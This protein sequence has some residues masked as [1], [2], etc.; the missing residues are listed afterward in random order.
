MPL[1]L[2]RDY[3]P[4][5][6]G[7]TWTRTRHGES[8]GDSP[9]DIFAEYDALGR[10]LYSRVDDVNGVREVTNTWDG[11]CL[12][13]QDIRGDFGRSESLSTCD[14]HGHPLEKNTTCFTEGD[15]GAE[16]VAIEDAP[17]FNTYEGDAWV[18]WD[19]PEDSWVTTFRFEGTNLVELENQVVWAETFF[20]YDYTW[21]GDRLLSVTTHSEDRGHGF[22]WGPDTTTWTYDKAGRITERDEAGRV[23]TYQYVGDSAW[24]ET[25]LEWT[26]DVL[27]YEWD[28]R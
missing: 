6:A 3:A 28:C 5:F 24:P 25:A 14:D 21:D 10:L 19:S 4:A 26:G 1:E 15:D 22:Q 8:Q 7:C 20:W 13:K 23:T 27:E 17:Y 9:E 16:T 2:D 11:P 18:G 12:E